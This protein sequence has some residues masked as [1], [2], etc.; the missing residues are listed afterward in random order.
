MRMEFPTRIFGSPLATQVSLPS[1]PRYLVS[2]SCFSSAFPPSLP[3]FSCYV[4]AACLKEK[5]V[6][7]ERDISSFTAIFLLR[8]RQVENTPAAMEAGGTFVIRLILL[9]DQP[10]SVQWEITKWRGGG[11]RLLH[12]FL[13][14]ATPTCLTAF[15]PRFL[16]PP[17]R[18]ASSYRFSRS[19]AAAR[20]TS[21]L[22]SYLLLGMSVSLRTSVSFV[23]GHFLSLAGGAGKI[24][25]NISVED[26]RTNRNRLSEWRK[27]EVFVSETMISEK[28]K[29]EIHLHSLCTGHKLDDYVS[30]LFKSH[31]T[32][33]KE[34]F[35]CF[36]STQI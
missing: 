20:G 26:L 33:I 2:V 22:E 21:R 25:K 17:R 10:V 27:R 9:M 15:I 36:I 16:V 18:A 29:V 35:K 14:L 32:L 12:N 4:S 3:L 28:C 13:V 24:R 31:W 30:A 34:I 1:H 5:P 19:R 6:V 11:K 23:R 8:R 7:K